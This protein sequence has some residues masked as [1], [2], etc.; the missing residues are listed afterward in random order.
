MI[1]TNKHGFTLVEILIV[2]VIL[3]ILAA[4]VIPQFSN[5]SQEASVNRIRADLQTMRSQIELYKI[6]HLGNAP[7]DN[8][9]FETQMTTQTAIGG[10]A[11]TDFGPY[12][13][14]VPVNAFTNTNT[15]VAADPGD[16]SAGW[17]YTVVGG[18]LA[19]IQACNSANYV[20]AA[21]QPATLAEF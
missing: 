13:Q 5:A 17:V 10:G 14:S 3:G 11:G 8:T 7:T 15:V 9:T 12:L 20:P 1:R 21:G 2:V 6:Q 16:G 19:T 4:I 18:T